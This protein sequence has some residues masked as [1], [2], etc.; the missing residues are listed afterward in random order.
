MQANYS[1]R[2]KSIPTDARKGVFRAS[3]EANE[4]VIASQKVIISK[5]LFEKELSSKP[6]LIYKLIKPP[7]AEL[8]GAMIGRA[9][10]S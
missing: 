5:M 3:V 6:L 9:S 7:K 2:W 10:L 4:S 8:S 1:N